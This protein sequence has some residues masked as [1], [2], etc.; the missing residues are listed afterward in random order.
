MLETHPFAAFVPPRAKYLLLGS[1]TVKQSI[2]WFYSSARN[3]FWPILRQVYHLPLTSKRAKQQLFTLLSLAVTDIIYQCERRHGTNSDANLVDIVY[4]TPNITGILQAH[5][6]R[7]IYF[8][9][10]FVETLFKK[11]FRKLV[12]KYPHIQLIT[13]PSPSPRYAAMSFTEKV[14]VYARLLPPLSNDQSATFHST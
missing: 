4:N 6:I 5:P 7:K 8:S 14:L 10:R 1:F 11:H 13:L 2:D 9:S 12:E 3:Q